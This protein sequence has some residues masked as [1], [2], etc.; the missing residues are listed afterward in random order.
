M[1][2]LT[3]VL[4]SC[5]AGN[6]VTFRISR[7]GLLAS[8]TEPAGSARRVVEAFFLSGTLK[9]SVGLSRIMS[10]GA[11]R[12]TSAAETA[13]LMYSTAASFGRTVVLKSA[14]GLIRTRSR[15][16]ACIAST[17]ATAGSTYSA[18]RSWFPLTASLK[19][20]SRLNRPTS[21]IARCGW[22]AS[23]THPAG[24][25]KECAGTFSARCDGRHPLSLLFWYVIVSSGGSGVHPGQLNRP[26]YSPPSLP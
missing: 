17:T 2:P 24:S 26:W 12:E 18:A 3:M 7:L 14:S 23:A 13:A 25:T 8:A 21:R 6:R 5:S 15:G 11:R 10:R 4:K 22:L 19:S 1:P 16:A 9:S 20:S